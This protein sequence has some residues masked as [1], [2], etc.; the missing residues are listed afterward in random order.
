[1]TLMTE[2]LLMLIRHLRPRGNFWITPKEEIEVAMVNRWFKLSMEEQG[3][4]NKLAY[5][6]RAKEKELNER[7]K[8]G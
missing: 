4:A 8:E 7:F 3:E 2:Y 5:E 6:L 1:M